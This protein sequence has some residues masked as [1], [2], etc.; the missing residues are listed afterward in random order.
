MAVMDAYL[1]HCTTSVQVLYVQSLT[2]LYATREIRCNHYEQN[3]PKL[4][5]L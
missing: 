5:A 3:P 4:S 2:V 1:L